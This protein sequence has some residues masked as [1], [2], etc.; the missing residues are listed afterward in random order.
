MLLPCTIIIPQVTTQYCFNLLAID[1]VVGV[2]FPN[3][4]RNVM[5]PRAVYALLL[6]YLC[7]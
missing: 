1:R 7:G 6:L 3:R 4:Y 2:A 5:K